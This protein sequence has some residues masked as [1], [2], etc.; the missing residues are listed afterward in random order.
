VIASY[1]AFSP[2]R[3][4]EQLRLVAAMQNLP[5]KV[6]GAHA[7][8][9]VGPDG[10]THQML[11]DVALMRALPN[12]T[13]LT[14]CD[15]IETA[16]ATRAAI[17]HPGPVYLRLSRHPSPVFTLPRSPFHVGKM[18]TLLAGN[19]LTMVSYGP[20]LH[21]V[22][23]AAKLLEADGIHA[24]VLN[25]S[26][27]APLDDKALIAAARQTGKVLVIEEAQAHG[28]LGSAV[29]QC[30]SEHYPTPMRFMSMHGFGTSGTPEELYAHF[31]LDRREIARVAR[32]L[33]A[34]P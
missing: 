10:G 4:W 30:L 5:I 20:I 27:L 31:K 8:I 14:P 12:F 18:P 24:R 6:I 21:E 11:E 23:W 29:A 1:A 32:E 34:A 9:S 19:D 25:A 3:N 16:K 22:L 7:G 15:A 2:G 33:I 26:C 17:A 28:G 13:I